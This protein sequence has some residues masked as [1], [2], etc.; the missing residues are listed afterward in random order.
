MNINCQISAKMEAI[1][2][3]KVVSSKDKKVYLDLKIGGNRIR[4]S[5]GSKFSIELFP[6]SYPENERI[7]QAN[8]LA[9]QVYA[10]L[11]AGES[12]Q[13]KNE[14]G[15]LDSQPDLYYIKRGSE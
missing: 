6:N 12:P 10:K 7:K 5:N 9:A 14:Q 1:N 8:I 2:Y 4:L 11:L 15:V 3:P 13:I